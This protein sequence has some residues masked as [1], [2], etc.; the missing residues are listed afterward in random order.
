MCL[1]KSTIC[2]SQSDVATYLKKGAEL[3]A[4]DGDAMQPIDME[5]LYGLTLSAFPNPFNE[6]TTISFTVSQSNEATL[7]LY[8]VKGDK[9]K[10]IYTGE[11]EINHIY[12]FDLIPG[13]IPAGVYMVRLTT[14]GDVKYIKL[15]KLN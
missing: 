14:Q 12:T 8:N 6:N 10:T 11:T 9:I 7:E 1:Q 13:N 5:D 15:V 2:V 3:G 4:C